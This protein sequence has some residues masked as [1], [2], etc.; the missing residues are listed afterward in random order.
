MDVHGGDE[1]KGVKNMKS[2]NIGI[3]GVGGAGRAHAIRF[4]KNNKVNKVIGYDIKKVNFSNIAVTRDFGEFISSVDAVSICSPDDTHF[5]YIKKCISYGKHVLVEKPM[6]ASYKEALALK[7]VIDQHKE[8]KFG[9]HHQMRYVPAF[10]KA[11]ELI[12]KNIL[13]DIFYIEANYWHDMRERNSRFD[14]WRLKGK[15]QSVIFGGACH[16][17]DLILYLVDFDILSHHTFVNK[18]A[19]R[20]Y[21][22]SYTS[23]TTVAKF[24]NNIIAKCHVNNCVIYPQF[25][26]LIILG[27]EGSYIDG[28]L[29]KNNKFDYLSR[30]N[31]YENYSLRF[32][33]KEKYFTMINKILNKFK[34]F[35]NN[36]YSVYNHSIA[37]Q[38]IIDNF[39]NSIINN[40]PILVRYDDGLRVVK[41]CEE[42]ENQ[43]MS[44]C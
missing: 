18:I 14:D 27:D 19:Y 1:E 35:R 3:I 30:C 40:E 13:G 44:T 29:Y 20:E 6:V 21:P 22:L 31:D 4:L 2:L 9:V 5:E 23:M 24:K 16:P 37:C 42:I 43:G 41:L 28:M 7:S 12:E 34:L 10:R 32:R 33:V 39:V 17:L 26:N 25:N 11:K 15:G 36:P 38:V 8:L